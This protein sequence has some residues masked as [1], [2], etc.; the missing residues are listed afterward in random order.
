MSTASSDVSA[1]IIP[2][3][4]GTEAASI[5]T[6]YAMKTAYHTANSRT[7][8][9]DTRPSAA[10]VETVAPAVNTTISPPRDITTATLCNI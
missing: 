2:A 5:V 9:S 6:T 10:P 4:A 7:A 8:H 1:P 3:T